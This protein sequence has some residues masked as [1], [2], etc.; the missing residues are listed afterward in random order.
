MKTPSMKVTVTDHEG[1]IVYEGELA[2]V[3]IECADINTKPERPDLASQL[4]PEPAPTP[5][6]R[7]PSSRS[8]NS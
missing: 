4:P 3:T 5:P 2:G 7:P 8:H 1:T 6:P